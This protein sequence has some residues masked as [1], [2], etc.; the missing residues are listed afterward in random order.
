MSQPAANFGQRTPRY[1]GKGRGS[2]IREA[3]AMTEWIRERRDS[4]GIELFASAMGITRRSAYRWLYELEEAHLV[5]RTSEPCPRAEKVE[6][7]MK[8]G[9]RS[10]W[11]PTPNAHR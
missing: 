11:V 6:S 10:F 7:E 5:Q 8:Y 1:K 2:Q 9:S 4:F 3:I